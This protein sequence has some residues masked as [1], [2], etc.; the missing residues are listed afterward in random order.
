MNDDDPL[1]LGTCCACHKSGPTVRNVFLL[2]K[3]APVPG[4]GWGCFQCGL[5]FDGADAVVCD[6]CLESK[7]PI[8]DAIYGLAEDKKR[9]PY[10]TLTGY[11]DHD[12]SKHPEERITPE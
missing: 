5:P 10:H 7:A 6:A 8:L 1:D 12:M 3:L 4:T 2:H 9:V 11:F